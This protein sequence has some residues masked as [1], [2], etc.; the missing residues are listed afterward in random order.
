MEL[1]NAEDSNESYEFRIF[2]DIVESEEDL[3][4]ISIVLTAMQLMRKPKSPQH[5]RRVKDRMKSLGA[6]YGFYL[7]IM[8]L[9]L[10]LLQ[11]EITTDVK[12]EFLTEPKDSGGTANYIIIGDS[13]KT[14]QLTWVLCRICLTILSWVT[15]VPQ[16]VQLSKLISYLLW[17]TQQFTW[18]E[19]AFVYSTPIIGLFMSYYL[20]ILQFELILLSESYLDIFLNFAAL[21][22]LTETDDGLFKFWFRNDSLDEVVQGV[23]DMFQASE[24]DVQER[25]ASGAVENILLLGQFL[26]HMRFALLGS[27]PIYIYA[28]ANEEDN[29]HWWY[30][31]IWIWVG[32]NALSF[33]KNLYGL[34]CNGVLY[35]LRL[36]DEVIYFDHKN[37]SGKKGVVL[38]EMD[39]DKH[40]HRSVARSV[41]SAEHAVELGKRQP[42]HTQEA[43]NNDTLTMTKHE[44]EHQLI[45]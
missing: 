4:F 44:S 38:L 7:F 13:R 33:L 14:P 39:I 35:R 45:L 1:L 12:F 28:W 3:L 43:P 10:G 27:Y 30:Q 41:Y 24:E 37:I 21:A 17:T 31:F 36:E 40:G 16:I 19:R 5:Y 9:A 26:R 22:V 29:R 42:E 34:C 25:M 2:P 8:L 6:L 18:C 20:S 15:I 23:D 32:I 11:E